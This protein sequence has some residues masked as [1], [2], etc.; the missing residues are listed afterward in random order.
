MM[1]VVQP[2]RAWTRHHECS[3]NV[4][5]SATLVPPQLSHE[6]AAMK[7]VTTRDLRNSPGAFRQ[8]V[9]REDVVL[10]VN[11]KPFAV[12]VGVED[13]EIDET[14]RLLRRLRAERAV[15]Q[16]RREAAE[17]GPDKLTDDE[18]EEEVRASRAQRRAR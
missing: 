6:T 11:G 12:V 15:S 10:T 17:R 3:Y 14:L 18:I 16:M 2:A 5:R 4:A 1:L 13:D 7:Y 9:S 8:T